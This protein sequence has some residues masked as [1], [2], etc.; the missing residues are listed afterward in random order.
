VVDQITNHQVLVDPETKDALE[1]D[2]NEQQLLNF[3]M[4][5]ISGSWRVSLVER[6]EP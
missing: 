1:E 3:V 2:P 5:L 4:K 6:V